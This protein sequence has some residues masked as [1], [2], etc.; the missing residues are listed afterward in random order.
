[1]IQ[2]YAYLSTVHFVGW[3]LEFKRPFVFEKTETRIGENIYTR[4]TF[5]TREIDIV[6]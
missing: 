5:I 6:I 4:E 3:Y 1:M 2:C